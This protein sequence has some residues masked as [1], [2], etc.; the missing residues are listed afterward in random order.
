[1]T[2]E[3]APQFDLETDVMQGFVKPFVS[4][5]ERMYKNSGFLMR[6]LVSMFLFFNK[7]GL[8]KLREKHFENS[9]RRNGKAFEKFKYYRFILL[10]S[11]KNAA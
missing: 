10:E 11:A 2:R 5:L 7:K 4:V 6:S 8:R 1:V 9:G 3:I